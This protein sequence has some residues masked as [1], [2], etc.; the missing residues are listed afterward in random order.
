[1]FLALRLQNVEP[2][3]GGNQHNS[4]DAEEQEKQ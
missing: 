4:Q 2:E 1:L 3:G